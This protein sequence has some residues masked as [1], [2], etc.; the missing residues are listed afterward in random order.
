M[1][2]EIDLLGFWLS[3]FLV[4][5][6]GS[7]LDILEILSNVLWKMES[8]RIL[9]MEMRKQKAEAPTLIFESG[10]IDL[11]IADIAVP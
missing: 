5:S 8:T 10:W 4:L 9:P 7:C 2:R 1:D 6:F 11:A 3:W